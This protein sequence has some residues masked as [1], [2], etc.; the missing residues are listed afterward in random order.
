LLRPKPFPV[1]VFSFECGGKSMNKKQIRIEM[2][3]TLK[4]MD[5]KKYN[6]SSQIIKDHFVASKAYTDARVIAITISRFPEV[7]TRPII[8]DAWEQGKTIVVPRCIPKTRDMDF[9]II[10]SFKDLETVY[11]DLLEPI[12]AETKSIEKEQIDIQI[13]PG[14]V[15]SEKGYRIGFGGGY[16]D[17]YLEGFQGEMIS[18]AFEAQTGKIIPVENHD[19]PVEKIITE[20]GMV[21][22][23][24]TEMDK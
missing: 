19:I 11:I 17:R 7:D 5:L 4:N 6:H 3:D 18:L 9:R 23:L 10:N 14:V 15:F 22:C 8:E 2:I 12:V 13:V 21:H 1:L 24:S 20:N 16:Y